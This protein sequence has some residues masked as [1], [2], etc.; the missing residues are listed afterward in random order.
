MRKKLL[1]VEDES[2]IAMLEKKELESYG[3]HVLT[4]P[5]GEDAVEKIQKGESIDLI[6]MD[7]DLGSGIDGTQAAQEIVGLKEIPI[8]F[9]SSHTEREVV[10]RTE[11]ITSY[12]YV[13]KNSG[14]VVL[15]TSIK[16]AF[17]LFETNKKLTNELAERQRVEDE[18]R[19]ERELLGRII[20]DGPMGITQV[21]CDGKIFFANHHARTLLALDESNTQDQYYNSPGWK[22]TGLDGS[23]IP[24]E[25]LPFRQI[26]ATGQ[27]VYDVH[28]AIVMPEGSQK[29]LSINGAPLHDKQ[30]RI[31]RIVFAIQDVTES[32]QI[33]AQLKESEGRYRNILEMAPVGIAIH[34]KGRVVYA[35]PAVLK[36]MGAEAE[37]QVL[38]KEISSFIHPDY[39]ERMLKRKERM[40]HGEE[41][42]YPAQD[43]YLR[44]DGRGIDVEVIAASIIFNEEPAV[45]IIITDI[46]ERKSRPPSGCPSQSDD[47]L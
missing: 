20:E 5:N 29:F 22:I 31:D 42:L 47:R 10:E 23:P 44:L 45:Q 1:L 2:I 7:I 41:G 9:L 14:T 6:L 33:E 37:E 12:G 26:M 46:T 21:D 30:G 8:I 36:I 3:Y 18:L 38:G 27:A 43:K 4:S 16:M 32:L 24:D 11:K 39:L 35:N 34:Q 17:K 19:Q 28:H 13:V 15:D 25:D 40:I